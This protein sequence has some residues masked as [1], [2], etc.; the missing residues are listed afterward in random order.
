MQLIPIM[1]NGLPGNVAKM[2]VSHVLRDSRFALVPFSLTGPEIQEA[3]VEVAGTSI[4]L[5]RPDVRAARIGDIKKQCPGLISVDYTH[6]TAVN[7]NCEFYCAHGLPFVMGTTGGDRD[8]LDPAVRASSICA[9]IAPNMAKQ[10]VG[11]QAMLAHAAD[12]FPGLFA[13]YTMTVRES[14]Q[15]GK[16]DTSGTARAVVHSFN[17]LGVHFSEDQIE[18][19]RDPEVQKREWGIPEEHLG[20]H[21]WHTYTLTSPD[22]TVTF[23]FKH[24]ING[25]D[26]YADGTLDAVV[27]L[28]QK[29]ARGEKG[30]VFSM[31]D[32]LT[33][34]CS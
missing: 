17:R 16:A 22:R 8:R 27:F 2:I 20:G 3:A 1:I 9:V 25:R 21:G 4:Q 5:V 11:F 18:M 15:K 29:V 33:G 28:H 19:I 26:I 32:V 31:I 7:G 34:G 30:T 14:H 6:P 23:E 10:V 13:G 24:N 12:T